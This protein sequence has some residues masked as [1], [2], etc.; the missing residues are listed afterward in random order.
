M[1]KSALSRIALWRETHGLQLAG[2]HEINRRRHLALLVEALSAFDRQRARRAA[3]FVGDEIRQ[4]GKRHA[5]VA[6]KVGAVDTAR[7]PNAHTGM[8]SSLPV[9]LRASGAMKKITGTP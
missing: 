1:P 8:P 4:F 3:Y 7:Y 2:A 6:Q 9:S 5:R